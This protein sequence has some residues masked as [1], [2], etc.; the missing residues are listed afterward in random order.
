MTDGTWAKVPAQGTGFNPVGNTG[1][2]LA[3]P[4]TIPAVTSV[5][6]GDYIVLL[7]VI[8]GVSTFVSIPTALYA[9]GVNKMLPDAPAP[10]A[11]TNFE[12]GTWLLNNSGL[13]G[14]PWGWSLS[15]T[16]WVPLNSTGAPVVVAPAAYSIKITSRLRP[17]RS[18]ASSASPFSA[19][20]A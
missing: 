6:D 10:P 9:L 2:S 18:P 17:P 11:S 13:A 3:N 14:A 12:L 1:G 19:A 15:S 8:G 4:A 7:R 5:A 20:P 16:G